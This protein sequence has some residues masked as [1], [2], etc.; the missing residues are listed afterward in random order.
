[1]VFIVSGGVPWNGTN[2]GTNSDNPLASHPTPGRAKTD[3]LCRNWQQL[4]T[5]FRFWQHLAAPGSNW[6][7]LAA[8]GTTPGSRPCRL[9]EPALAPKTPRSAPQYLTRGVGLKM[10]ESLCRSGLPRKPA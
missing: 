3:G 10:M 6:Q 4:A 2:F 1:M 8:S 5:T 9:P 7:H